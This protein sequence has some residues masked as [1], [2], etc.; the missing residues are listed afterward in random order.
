MISL[1]T[2]RIKRVDV[3]GCVVCRPVIPDS[4]VV[5]LPSIAYLGGSRVSVAKG[6]IY[7]NK[8]KNGTIYLKI[9]VL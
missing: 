5:L 6:N 8:N 4:D 7:E 1:Q 2:S 9:M 3:R